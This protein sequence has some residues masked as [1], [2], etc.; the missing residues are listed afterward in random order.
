MKVRL[1]TDVPDCLD[2]V[3]M[4]HQMNEKLTITRQNQFLAL[5]EYKIHDAD[6]VIDGRDRGQNDEIRKVNE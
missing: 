6:E 5:E 4:Q 1:R 3:G 2:K